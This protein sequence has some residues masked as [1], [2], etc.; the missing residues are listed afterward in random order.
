MQVNR[1]PSASGV[2]NY[3][4]FRALIK[5]NP[6][7]EKNCLCKRA[8]TTT[9]FVYNTPDRCFHPTEAELYTLLHHLLY[10]I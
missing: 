9:C 3:V 2:I 6:R 10:L 8:R 1:H 5:S 7:E 4:T